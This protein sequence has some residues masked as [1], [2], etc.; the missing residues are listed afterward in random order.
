[1]QTVSCGIKWQPAA[2][3]RLAVM[4]S[5]G[6]ALQDN[7]VLLPSCSSW[8]TATL[9]NAA[10]K[11]KQGSLCFLDRVEIMSFLGS[12]KQRSFVS[13]WQPQKQAALSSTSKLMLIFSTKHGKGEIKRRIK[14]PNHTSPL[15]SRSPRSCKLITLYNKSRAKAGVSRCCCKHSWLNRSFLGKKKFWVLAYIWNI[16]TFENCFAKYWSKENDTNFRF[17]E[18]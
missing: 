12:S 16:W 5:P 7:P 14:N 10:N 8:P 3:F 13:V 4:D 1:M 18:K 2:E 17:F 11:N 9:P 15:M 6:R